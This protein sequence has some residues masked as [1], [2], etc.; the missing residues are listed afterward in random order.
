M[1]RVESSPNFRDCSRCTGKSCGSA[2]PPDRRTLHGLRTRD[3]RT[4]H[5][6]EHLY[7]FN[8]LESLGDLT[9][10][11]LDGNRLIAGVRVFLVRA[12]SPDLL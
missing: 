7:A 9:E 5:S 3:R 11:F 12:F 4:G 6:R 1:R 10:R 8:G 2:Y